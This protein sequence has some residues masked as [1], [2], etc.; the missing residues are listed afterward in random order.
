MELWWRGALAREEIKKDAIEWWREWSKLGWH[1]IAVKGVS[2]TV[3]KGWPAAVMRIQCFS[4]GL[5]G[6]TTGQSVA[7]RWSRGKKLVLASREGSVT[8]RDD[9][10]RRRGGTREKKG[11]KQ[12]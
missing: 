8:R 10:G 9:V 1:F 2:Q 11:R 12:C 4:F 6:K 5:R 7:G 3:H